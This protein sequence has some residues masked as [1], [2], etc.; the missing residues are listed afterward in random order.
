MDKINLIIIGYFGL[1]ALYGMAEII[2]LVKFDKGFRKKNDNSFFLMILPFY[3]SVYLPP[4]E[5]VLFRPSL[6]DGTLLV[7]FL[8][9]IVGIFIRIIALLQL[10]HNFST[11]VVIKENSRLVTDGLYRFIR[12]PLYLAVLLMTIPGSLIFSCLFTWIFVAVTLYGILLRIQKEEQ[13]L[14]EHYPEYSSY[15]KRS[16][17]LI[18]LIY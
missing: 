10:R 2:L 14:K 3:L 11:A 6:H 15:M 9:L 12:H 1:I 16:R 8:L 4:A 13:S 17:K 7:G 18:P 5:Y